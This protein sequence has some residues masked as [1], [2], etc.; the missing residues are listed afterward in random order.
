[1]IHVVVGTKAQLIKIAP[2]MAGLQSRNIA[3]NFIFTGQHQQTIAQLRE[4]FGIKEPDVTLC[5]GRDITGIIQMFFWMTR[6]LFKTL[7]RR[8]EIFPKQG[9]E[10]IVLVHGDTFS[11]LLGALMG[12]IAGK[13]IGH[14]ES[15]LRSFNI[16]HPF[17]EE[18]TRLLTF[19]LS[20]Y[21]FCP[22]N[23]AMANVE[24]YR[25]TKI[26]TVFN[27]LF[28]A[29]QLARQK[30]DSCTVEVPEDPFALV[31][32]HRFEN[33]FNRKIFQ[34]IV[35]LLLAISAKMPLLF[36]L[37]PPTEEK[38]KSFG[39]YERLAAAPNISLRPRYDYFNFVKLLLRCEFLITDGG[40]NQEEAHYLGKPT[41]LF[42]RATER[43]EGVGG[44]VVISNFEATTINGFVADY[45]KHETPPVTMKRSPTE[46][47][48]ES[49]A[50][51]NN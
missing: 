46:I 29:L 16:F 14:V 49:L 37:H 17:P 36:I 34:A 51:F 1:M 3:V 30:T 6:I 39:F 22:G 9:K 32:L 25:G 12:K 23:W 13:K 19:S 26:N 21:Y 8:R 10:D 50:P 7:F 28:D 31:S 15:G 44:N 33:I 35:D 45:K 2:V 20:D 24:K 41:L 5:S 47:I 40:S 11:T 48:I 42:R 38:L 43:Q 18:I 4:N 27:T